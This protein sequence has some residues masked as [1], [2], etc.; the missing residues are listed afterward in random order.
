MAYNVSVFDRTGVRIKKKEVIMSKTDLMKKYEDV[1][2]KPFS[3][4]TD[5]D[6]KRFEKFLKELNNEK[7]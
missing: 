6:W 4:F 5:K 1:L 3:E 7:D 2:N